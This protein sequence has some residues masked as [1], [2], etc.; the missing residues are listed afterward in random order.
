MVRPRRL[1]GLLTLLLLALI[2]IGVSGFELPVP[3][4]GGATSGQPALPGVKALSATTLLR[5]GTGAPPGGELAFMAVE[6]SGNLMVSDAKRRT[7]MRFDASGHLL[8]EWGPRFDQTDLGEPAGVAVQGDSYYVVDRGAQ[9]RIFRLDA[10]GQLQATF[11]LQS[12]STYGLNGLALDANGNLYTADTGRNRILVF[13]PTGQLLRQVGRGGSD[14][15]GFTQPMMLAFGPDGTFFV[16]D[17]ENNRIERWNANFEATDAWTTGF[18]A[19]GVA[20]DQTG[21]VFVPDADHRRVEAYSPQG[22]SLGEMGA[23][24]SPTIDVVPRQVA[25]TRS[26]ASSLYVLGSDGIQRLD[27]EN[28]AAPPQS[29]SGDTDPLSLGVIVLLVALL[30]VAVLSR[31]QR[32]LPH[33]LGAA[34][35]RPVG[36]QAKNGAQPQHQKA[37]P[38]QDLLVAHQPE[39]KQ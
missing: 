12:L 20:V 29:A 33:S 6:P 27:L 7:V 38:D 3:R 17:W 23:P 30:V 31:R 19:F 28:T 10:T 2:A 32:R 1:V 14:L 4:F 22:A 16:A 15:G 5:V 13:S 36:L 25:L 9:P 11:N 39:G 18:H 34:L 24:A 21:R 26:E 35:D 37:Q 8:S